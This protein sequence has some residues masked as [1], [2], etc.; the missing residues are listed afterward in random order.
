MLWCIASHAG[1]ISAEH[2]LGLMKANHIGY[3]KS[4]AMVNM[5]QKIKQLVD[6]KGIMNPYKYL[7]ERN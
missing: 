3:S 2:G 4:P 5:M 1:S 7:P 6:P